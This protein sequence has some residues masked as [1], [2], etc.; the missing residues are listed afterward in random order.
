MPTPLWDRW[1]MR[2]FVFMVGIALAGCSA[3]PDAPV[4]ETQ[5][6]EPVPDAGNDG[7]WGDD[8]DPD[9]SGEDA[10][11]LPIDAPLVDVDPDDGPT[12]AADRT[13]ADV[14]DLDAADS[15][16]PDTGRDPGAMDAG[17]PDSPDG[18]EPDAQ[19]DV[20]DTGEPDIPGEP[21]VPAEPDVPEGPCSAFEAADYELCEANDNYCQ[22]I[23]PEGQN[24]SDIC[25]VAQMR[26]AAGFSTPVC[27]P[28]LT[29]VSCNFP[30]ER[31]G[32]QCRCTTCVPV[33]GD[34]ECG[35]DGC[36]G[37]CG[38][39]DDDEVCAVGTC[40]RRPWTDITD[41]AMGFAREVTGGAEGTLCTVTTN[42]DAG[43]GT[44]RD[45][46]SEPGRWIRFG[47]DMG[48]GLESELHVPSD[49]TIDGRGANV[50]INSGTLVI[51]AQNV[52]VYNVG[53]DGVTYLDIHA[54]EIRD[55]AARV[56]LHHLTM[57]RFAD[58][59]IR[60]DD[61][62]T[63]VTI[64][65]CW[66]VSLERG[67]NIGSNDLQS[68]GFNVRVTVHHNL[69]RNVTRWTPRL[70]Q[71]RLHL[72]NNL[73]DNWDALGAAVTI[74][75]Q[76]LSENNVYSNSEAVP[77]VTTQI[78]GGPLGYTRSQGDLA[79]G[80]S[81][82]HQNEPERVFNPAET[83]PYLIVPAD[84]ALINDLNVNVG[85]REIDFPE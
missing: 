27:G 9:A 17:R 16:M 52:V 73:I 2:T 67:V 4:E 49:T 75:G 14:A 59:A 57:Q 78:D 55:G 84:S 41:Q 44:L 54:I 62:S 82:V 6:Q 71:G 51:A 35:D 23:A 38:L 64:S 22:V 68:D 65:R 47:R 53:F 37:R 56:W 15:E 34:R 61:S 18:D 60:I 20:T 5:L 42:A 32:G 8:G 24:C 1:V 45:C 79:L 81:F 7:H 40:E 72:F 69:F 33:C 36:G 76:L 58:A 39:C 12:D 48:I 50:S 77:T 11:D 66:F 21:D 63:D 83:Y 31:P 85:R 26:C 29:E 80:S 10:P 30:Q 46:L 43:P 28:S 25:E 19:P 70:R 13:D 3:F 74:G